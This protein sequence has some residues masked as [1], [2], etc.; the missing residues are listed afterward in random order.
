MGFFLLLLAYL[1]GGRCERLR[2]AAGIDGEQPEGAGGP[3]LRHRETAA[4]RT[5]A[6]ACSRG[7]QEASRRVPG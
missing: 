1:S 5:A 2:H 3:R 6:A 7:A 4:F